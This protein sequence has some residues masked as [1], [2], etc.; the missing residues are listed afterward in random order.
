MPTTVPASGEPLA[1]RPSFLLRAAPALVA[2]A[3]LLLFVLPALDPEVQLFYRDTGRLYYPLRWTIAQRLASFQLPLWDPWTDAGIS[4]FGQLTPAIL[5]PGTLLYYV[6]PFDLAFKLHHLLALPVAALGVHLLSRRLGAG[7]WAALAGGLAYGTCGFVVSMVAS[8]LPYAWGAATMPFAVEAFL[9]FLER[10]TPGRLLWAA[11][12]LALCGLAGDAQAMEFAG[13]IGTAWALARPL[14]GVGQRSIQARLEGG[15]RG[16]LLAALWGA[17]ALALA[18]PALFPAAARLPSSA[19]LH[20][21]TERERV[22]FSIPP[23]RLAGVLVPR[24]FDDLSE[25]LADQKGSVPTP[26]DEYFSEGIA[27]FS[28]SIVIGAPALLLAAMAIFAGRRGRFLLLGGLVLLIASTGDALGLRPILDAVIP[29]LKLFRYSEKLIGPA[30]LLLCA[31]AALGAERALAVGRRSATGLLFGSLAV[32]AVCAGLAFSCAGAHPVWLPALLAHGKT[33]RP[34]LAAGFLDL[35]ASGLW[36]SAGLA[37]A[38]ALVALLTILR[39]ALGPPAAAFA[40]LAAGLA[41]TP[42]QLSV[43]PLPLLRPDFPLAADLEQRAGPSPGRWRVFTHFDRLPVLVGLDDKVGSVAAL[44]QILGPHLNTLARVEGAHEYF[45]ASDPGYTELWGRAP[46][47]MT[48]LLGVRFTILLSPSLSPKEAADLGMFAGPLGSFVRQSNVAPRAFVVHK[49]R[50][51][52]RPALLAALEDASFEPQRESYVAPED[53]RLLAL[54]PPPAA[55]PHT[56]LR[57]DHPTPEAYD[58]ETRGD[59]GLLVVGEHHDEGW[60]ASVDGLQAPVLRVNGVALGVPV[61]AG[62]HTVRLRFFPRGL[63]PGALSAAFALLVLV[64]ATVRGAFG[65]QKVADR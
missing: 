10:T 65:G 12:A 16:G 29:G 35:A 64:A 39:P 7:R 61:G 54:P 18:A 33:H 41:T 48:R 43:A 51:L 30:S 9:A 49:A 46:R 57:W 14:G 53:E 5:H 20:G 59:A 28:E 24:A 50:A 38:L 55:T 34:A 1:A 36:L 63:L 22:Y 8:N 31:A 15:L 2:A 23:A 47:A 58:L 44:G 56:G 25:N 42:A 62:S 19:R 37:A 21:S 60:S 52:P 26:Y 17:T 40:C 6:L 45:S 32:A 27:A 11:A 4:L 3:G 13:L